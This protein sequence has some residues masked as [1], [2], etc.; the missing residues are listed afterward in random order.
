MDSFFISFNCASTDGSKK[1]VATDATDE[2]K[3]K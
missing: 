1:I 3:R 2:L